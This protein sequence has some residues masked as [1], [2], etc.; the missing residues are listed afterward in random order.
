MKNHTKTPTTLQRIRAAQALAEAEQK[1][2]D[3]KENAQRIEEEKLMA[4]LWEIFEEVADLPAYT[5]RYSGP[6]N[7]DLKF[8]DHLSSGNSDRTRMEFWNGYGDYGLAFGVHDGALWVEKYLEGKHVVS[9]P[10]QISP[11][12]GEQILIAHIA[13]YL[14]K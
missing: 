2:T 4:G 6:A 9:T 7:P 14:K 12:E 3:A 10:K 11:A 1:A 8:R 5:Y 13:T